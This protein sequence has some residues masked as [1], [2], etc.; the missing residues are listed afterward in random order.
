MS[1]AV[2]ARE[3]DRV[4]QAFTLY[5]TINV[6]PALDTGVYDDGCAREKFSANGVQSIRRLS[7]RGRPLDY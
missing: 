2:H 4:D 6:Q 1:L 5:S 3:S 7:G